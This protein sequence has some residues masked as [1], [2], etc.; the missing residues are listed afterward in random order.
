MHPEHTE[1]ADTETASNPRPRAG[2]R[3]REHNHQ[4]MISIESHSS[5]HQSSSQSPKPNA[6]QPSPPQAPQGPRG[7]Q[8]LILAP[9]PSHTASITWKSPA[10]LQKEEYE[11]AKQR[12]RHFAPEQL[13]PIAKPTF[14]PSEIFP[15]NASEYIKHKKDM[16]AMREAQLLQNAEHL[17]EKMK[18]WESIPPG[19]RM[20]RP[21][22]GGKVFSDGLSPVLMQQTVW[23]GEG[24]TAEWPTMEEYQWHKD[25][26][27]SHTARALSGHFLP[28]PRE[29]TQETATENATETTPEAH[30]LDRPVI[31]PNPFDEVQTPFSKGPAPDYY[32]S[33][34]II[35]NTDPAFEEKGQGLVGAGLMSEVGQWKKPFVPDWQMPLAKADE[36]DVNK[37]KEQTLS[38]RKQKKNNDIMRSQL[39]IVQAMHQP[40]QTNMG[41]GHRQAVHQ[42]ALPPPMYYPSHA[43]IGPNM[44][45]QGQ[46]G[47]VLYPAHGM[48][49]Q[50]YPPMF[51][52]AQGPHNGVYTNEG[53]YMYNGLPLMVAPNMAN[54][55]PPL[56]GPNMP[57]ILPPTMPRAMESNIRRGGQPGMDRNMYNGVQ[58]DMAPTLYNGV[59]PGT[60]PFMHNG[61]WYPNTGYMPPPSG[62]QGY[63]YQ[64]AFNNYNP[65]TDQQQGPGQYPGAGPAWQ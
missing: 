64:G 44:A 20:V 5:S 57:N 6:T 2:G 9:G 26:R 54:V 40:L 4:N 50:G 60:G 62:G 45:H 16:M 39:R 15:R 58:P 56:V 24:G 55:L 52:M 48:A 42:G 41:F 63:Q 8:A 35:L 18:A 28:P 53:Q 43:D 33:H 1:S 23:D 47:E 65:G 17:K 3:G 61:V 19:L 32:N 22:F 13:R 38:P 31:K 11:R 14:G 59:Q 34:N 37:P 51:P 46:K 36:N 49:Q 30:S 10:V 12:M 29:P 25:N 21:A 7:S 27:H